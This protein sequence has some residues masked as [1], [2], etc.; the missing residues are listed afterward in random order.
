[1]NRKTPDVY[2]DYAATTPVK[3]AVSKL[4]QAVE[5]Q[6]FGNPSSLHAKG[7]EALDVLKKSRQK[8]AALIGAREQEIVFCAGGTESDNLAL[9]GVVRPI[10]KKKKKAHV[11]I[12][13]IEHHAILNVAKELQAEGAEISYAAVDEQG[14]LRAKDVLALVR[15]DTALISIIYANNEIGTIEPIAEITKG[16]RKINQERKIAG[17]AAL[18]LHTDAC[19]AAGYL[20]LNVQKLG[21]DLMTL[22]GSKIYGPRQFGILYVKKGLVLDPIIFGGGQ[23]RGLRSGTENVAAAAGF[24]L[25]LEIVQK[26][27]TR[28]HPRLQKLQEYFLARLQKEISGLQL[29]GPTPGSLRLPNNIN[30][31]IKGSDGESMVIYLDAAGIRCSTGS[32]CSTAFTEPSHVILAISGQSEERAKSSLRFSFGQSTTKREIDYIASVLKQL[33]AQILV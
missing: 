2:A 29:N 19:Q 22:N 11:I 20:E 12:S 25:A 14:L 31:S 10:L 27:C 7:Q 3:P 4:M 23:E 21:V 26:N 30:I 9:F 18:L 1:M 28:E 5:A 17:L 24:A 13:P 33:A 15:P 16:L 8:I 32:A 6:A